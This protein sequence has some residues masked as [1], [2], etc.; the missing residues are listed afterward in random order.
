MK[1]LLQA[2][3]KKL[4][5]GRRLNIKRVIFFQLIVY[6]AYVFI[7]SFLPLFMAGF[8]IQKTTEKQMMVIIKEMKK[9]QGKN[10]LLF[11]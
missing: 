11:R 6:A 3:F 2:P 10:I 8:T 7:V 4:S 5:R 1:R 9:K